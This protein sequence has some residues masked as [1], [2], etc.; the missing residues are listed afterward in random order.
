MSTNDITGDSMTSKPMSAESKRLFDE[1]FNRIFGK[2]VSKEQNIDITE[3]VSHIPKE[4]CEE[5]LLA[6]AKGDDW[7]YGE[8]N[9]S[10]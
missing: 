2:K 10:R 5:I 3:V 4:Y 7:L 6:N 8:F 9:G 1:N